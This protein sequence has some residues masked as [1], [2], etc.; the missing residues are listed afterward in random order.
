MLRRVRKHIDFGLALEQVIG[1]LHRVDR[2]GL[3]ELR[4]LRRRIIGHAD[5]AD[6][7]LLQQG[8]ERCGRL[9][10]GDERIGPMHLVKVDVVGAQ[11]P[12]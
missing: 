7:A 11:A 6:L 12:Q 9:M 1:R 5:C 10:N 4:H 2:S 3:P 8:G